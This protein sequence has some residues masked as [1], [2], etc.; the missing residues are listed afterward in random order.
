M[1]IDVRILGSSG[2]IVSVNSSG[3]LVVGPSSFSEPYT[4]SVTGTT[5]TNLVRGRVNE[6][7]VV[8]DMIISQ[9]RTNTD[10]AVTVFE[11]DSVDGPSTDDIITVDLIKSQAIPL[12]GLNLISTARGKYINFQSDSGTATIRVT[13]MGYYRS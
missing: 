12:T 5:I 11:S 4:G 6:F 10:S 9:D 1:P 7:F 2:R 8:T 13:V 3:E